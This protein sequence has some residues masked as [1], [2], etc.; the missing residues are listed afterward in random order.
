MEENKRINECYSRKYGKKIVDRREDERGQ[1]GK[2]RND[3]RERGVKNVSLRD[4]DV[5]VRR[6]RERSQKR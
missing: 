6:H 3:M 4:E 1:I 2:Q 5:D